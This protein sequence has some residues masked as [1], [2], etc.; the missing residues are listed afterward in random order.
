MSSDESTVLGRLLEELSWEGHERIK[1]AYRAGGRGQENVL[2]A[3]VLM[4]LD[5]LPRTS[6]LGAVLL[7]AHGGDR[8]RATAAADVEQLRLSFLDQLYVPSRSTPDKHAFEVQP[9][10]QLISDQSYVLVEAK[11]IRQAQ[12][13]ARQLSRE[14]VTVLQHAAD[15][16]PLLLLILGSEPPVKVDKHGRLDIGQ[17]IRLYLEELHAQADIDLTLDE[18]RAR[19]D[20][21][22]AWITWAEVGD[23]VAR[24]AQSFKNSDS[25]V[26]GG[27]HRLSSAIRRAVAWHS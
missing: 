19:V 23:I 18:L 16:V 20:D 9:D 13:Q 24:Q 21:T 1:S 11:R 3:E 8:A 27:V 4:P 7:A 5:F 14:Y 25:S 22:W 17:A 6:F 26:V 15:R 10:A 12:F 2:A